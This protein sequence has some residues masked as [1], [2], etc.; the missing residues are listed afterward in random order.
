MARKLLRLVTAVR[1]ECLSRLRKIQHQRWGLCMAR[2]IHCL[3]VEV[4][5]MSGT[6]HRSREPA[7]FD[8]I[9]WADPYI[10]S[11]VEKLRHN[12]GRVLGEGMAVQR[13]VRAEAPPPLDVD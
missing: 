6:L 9:P 10:A 7:F 11:L 12:E 13:R 4:P 1:T 3:A 5:V 2:N 8:L